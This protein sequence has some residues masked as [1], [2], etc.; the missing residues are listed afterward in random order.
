MVPNEAP[1]VRLT[2]APVDTITSDGQRLKYFYAYKLNW[3]G[4]DPDGRV[5]HFL[6][7][8]DRQ[9]TPPGQPIRWTT[10]Q[11]YEQT[12]FFKS[13][14]PEIDTTTGRPSEA[15]PL[16]D[17]FHIFW[18][19]AVNTRGA[20]SEVPDRAFFS[21][22]QA[23]SVDIDEPHPSHLAA[24]LVTPFVRVSWHGQDPDGQF[25]QKPVKY[26]FKLFKAGNNEFDF[27]T[28]KTNP[29]SLRRFY[30]PNFAGWDS[31]GPESTF[32]TYS[33]LVPNSFYIFV[34]VVFDEAGAY[35]PIFSLDHNIVWMQISFAGQSGPAINIYNEF[36]NYQYGGGGFPSTQQEKIQRPIFLEVPAGIPIRFNWGAVASAGALVKQYRWMMDNQNLDDETPRS[37]ELTDTFHWS[38]WSL[39][40]V[41][42]TVGPFPNDTTHYFFVEAEDVNGL[43]S[44]GI[45]QF[46]VIPLPPE[47]QRKDLAVVNDTRLLSDQKLFFPQPS[48]PDS[49]QNP[50]GQW[51]S[52]AELDTFLFAN[53]GRDPATNAY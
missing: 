23:P 53:G 43:V 5:D 40:N 39:S 33:N 12:F 41:N 31:T 51:P 26:K 13:G 15:N 44:L 28:I 2:A 4:Y 29:D 10:T 9:K 50:P 7:A 6:Y 21:F 32:V 24:A 37:N 1:T 34:V 27:E 45:V 52:R 3:V 8:I 20:E 22:T 36:F 11:K 14:V 46:H 25:T 17:D 42:C 16:A 35:S 38:Q 49:L 19:K 18:I 48:N 47:N 30:A